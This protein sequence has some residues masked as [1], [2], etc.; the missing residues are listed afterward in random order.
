MCVFFVVWFL[1]LDI[2]GLVDLSLLTHADL[3]YFEVYIYQVDAPAY[4]H[5]AVVSEKSAYNFSIKRLTIGA[6]GRPGV[7]KVGCLT[8]PQILFLL[9]KRKISHRVG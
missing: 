3:Q 4:Y 8:R 7:G 6:F 9:S 5:T 2:Y 1:F